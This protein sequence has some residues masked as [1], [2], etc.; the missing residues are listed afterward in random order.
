LDGS[1]GGPSRD[2]G[3]GQRDDLDAGQE[4]AQQIDRLADAALKVILDLD[5]AWLLWR[6]GTIVSPDS[7]AA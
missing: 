7:P 6:H 4:A 1:R 5:L 3:Q 2:A